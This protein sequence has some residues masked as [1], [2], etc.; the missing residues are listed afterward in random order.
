MTAAAYSLTARLASA[1]RSFRYPAAPSRV[2]P[3]PETRAPKVAASARRPTFEASPFQSS[4]TRLAVLAPRTTARSR[5]LLDMLRRIRDYSPDASKAVENIITL[6][7]PGYD[8]NVY[9]AK[10]QNEA[11]EPVVDAEGLRLVQQFATRVCSEYSGAWDEIAGKASTYP[12]L[13]TFIA[14][15]HL[16]VATQG[17][18]AAE[19]ELTESLDDIVDVYPVDPSIIDFRMN[20]QTLRLEPGLALGGPFRPLDPIRFRYIGKDP[21]VNLPGGRSPL[22]AV[23]DTI[24]FQQQFMREL[25]AIAHM[26]NA[27]RLDVKIVRETALAAIDKARPDLNQPG[28]QENK[29]AYLDGFLTDVQD[30]IDSLEP[31][32]AF[33]HWD[34][35][36][37]NYVSPGKTAVGVGELMDAVDRLII[38]GLKQLPILLGRN[39]GAT[40][41]HAT[42]QWQVYV[43]QLGGY[44]RIS[45]ALV[46]WALNLYLRIQGRQS[47]AVLCY[48]EHRTNDELVEAQTME[49]RVRTWKEMVAAGWATDD[50]AA[51]DLLG[52]PAVAPPKAG[53]PEEEPDEADEADE[54]VVDDTSTDEAGDE[55]AERAT[56][57]AP[58]PILP[59]V[60][61]KDVVF[62]AARPRVRKLAPVGDGP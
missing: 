37:V 5:D 21:D 31:D 24:L 57:R 39:E 29:R 7:N 22:L 20:P 14:L 1:W 4:L 52:H 51:Q 12:G 9:F 6:A 46:T 19:V 38:S 3:R 33:I 60:S 2:D 23:I 27:P 50:E 13:D 53:E 32:D 49:T 30:I 25:Q 56:R 59:I 17:A 36:E 15:T 34:D 26:S 11:G 58:V 28:Q 16:T 45:K 62:A 54:A 10:G 55:A 40:T 44:Q 61:S 42:V 48:K 47:Y 43:R 8:L 18:M 41:T 35:A